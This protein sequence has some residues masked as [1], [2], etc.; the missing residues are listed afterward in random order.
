MARLK[1]GQRVIR[2]P[3]TIGVMPEGKNFAYALESR[4]MRGVVV[5]VHKRGRFHVVEFPNGL[6]ETFDG[7]E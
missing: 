3:K 1:V 5:F 4:P 7:V 2:T 6:R